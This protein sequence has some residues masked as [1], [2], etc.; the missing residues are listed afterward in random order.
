[1]ETVY[2]NPYMFLAILDGKRGVRCIGPRHVDNV[3]PSLHE[4]LRG[5]TIHGIFK[6]GHSY[7]AIV[8][9][10][11]RVVLWQHT[12][13]GWYLVESPELQRR[14]VGVCYIVASRSAFAAYCRDDRIVTWKYDPARCTAVELP[15]KTPSSSHVYATPMGF[16]ARSPK[17]RLSIMNTG[18]ALERI[19]C[20]CP[21]KKQKESLFRK[22]YLDEGRG[23]RDKGLATMDCGDKSPLL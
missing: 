12:T 1:M 9:G 18:E 5:V 13:T 8:G 23:T 17:D 14:L 19:G 16:I 21:G 22:H 6:S 4:A 3:S 15:H 10:T 7:A 11:R 2:A 20:A